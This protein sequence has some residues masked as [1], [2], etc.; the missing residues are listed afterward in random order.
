MQRLRTSVEDVR[1]PGRKSGASGAV[2]PGGTTRTITPKFGVA[3][4]PTMIKA[5]LI[6]PRTPVQLAK[7]TGFG[8]ETAYL[9]CKSMHEAGLIRIVE[10]VFNKN[11]FM[12]AYLFGPG[13]DVTER[14]TT[15][16]KTILDL[17]RQDELSRTGQEVADRLNLS[18]STITKDLNALT[19]KG[20][21][22]R[23]RTIR[24]N[25]PATW[26]R[27]PDVA[28]PTFGASA[29]TQQ[30]IPAAP[31]RPKLKISQQTWFSTIHK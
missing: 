11:K 27:N 14:W 7:E 31:Q 21:L 15:K 4:V 18:R 19:D 29:G 22:I 13:E 10:W 6:T 24:P 1:D 8:V 25:D 26:R 12:P 20:Y 30:G 16:E 23:N 17:F 3:N 2:K 5:I 9:F 28:F